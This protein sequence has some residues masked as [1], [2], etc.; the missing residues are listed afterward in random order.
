M[1]KWKRTVIKA[2]YEKFGPWKHLTPAATLRRLRKI[3]LKAAKIL[4]KIVYGIK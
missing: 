4:K 3:D 1:N 2:K